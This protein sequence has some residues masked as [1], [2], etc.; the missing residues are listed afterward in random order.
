MRAGFILSEVWSGLRKNVSMVLSVVLVT[1]VSLLFVGAAI[2]LQMQVGQMKDYW[3]DR[4]QVSVF[5]CPPDSE[6][7]N[8]VE[9]EATD[10]QKKNIEDQLNSSELAP[11]VDEVYFEDKGEAFEHFQDQFKGTSLEGTVPEDEMNESFRVKLQDAEKYDIIK[12]SFSSTQ[13]VEEVVDQN[14]LLD[15]LFSVLNIATV[16]AVAIAGIMLL[17]AM[18][19]IA[20]TIR[21]SAFSRRRETGIMRLVGASNTFIQL[22]FLLEG[23]IA[24]AIGA[25]LSAGALGLLVHFGVSGWLEGQATGFSLISGVNVLIVAPILIAIGVIMAGASSL[26]TLNKYTKV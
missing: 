12:E 19:L 24:S 16:V 10:T 21:L 5:L 8:C 3:Y 25:T 13:G 7:T 15:R 20:T 26:I 9:G 2:L 23:V 17:C 4:V 1:F 22:P 18:L 6:A 11:Y 14:Q